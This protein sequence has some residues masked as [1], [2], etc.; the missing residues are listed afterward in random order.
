[1]ALFWQ[2]EK[3]PREY[4]VPYDV[5]DLSF[6]IRART[7]P[8]DHAHAL[9]AALLE[10]LPWLAE[11][12]RAGIHLIHVAESGNGWFRP[13]DPDTGLLHVSRRT[14]MSLRLPRERVADARA[15]TG[16]RLDVAGHVLEVGEAAEKP[17]V[18]SAV[19]FARYVVAEP[20]EEETAFLERAAAGLRELGVG[21]RKLMAG[22]PH[23]F[24]L[25]GGGLHTRSLMVA[26]LSPE[27]SVRLQQEGLGDG[28]KL[29]CGLFL[30]HKGIAAV[31][32]E[33][34]D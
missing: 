2:E 29:G 26:D 15:L 3:K 25:P 27:E 8:V 12:P 31:K 23:C 7:L 32:S 5:L 17:F 10:A 14:R 28:R 21:V 1:M 20:D 11:E 33:G 13:E 19:V 16:Q 18:A 30:P 34:D 9:S 6:R 22:R 4:T 24:R